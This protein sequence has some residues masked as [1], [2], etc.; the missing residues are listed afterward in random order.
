[1]FTERKKTRSCSEPIHDMVD[2]DIDASWWLEYHAWNVP[3]AFIWPKV[4]K[5]ETKAPNTVKYPFV[6]GR[7]SLLWTS[8]V[9]CFQ[10]NSACLSVAELEGAAVLETT[11]I[12][13]MVL[14]VRSLFS[15]SFICTTAPK[16]GEESEEA[17]KAFVGTLVIVLY[18]SHVSIWT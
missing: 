17:R 11:E 6:P 10:P 3:N 4:T 1:M 9:S 13:P 15:S 18:G 2:C 7:S 8:R 16:K 12:D 14:G 5:R